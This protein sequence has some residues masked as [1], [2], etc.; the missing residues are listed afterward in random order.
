MRKDLLRVTM[1][2]FFGLA[3]SGLA[4]AVYAQESAS[5]GTVMTV[6]TGEGAETDAA[7]LQKEQASPEKI[8]ES[9]YTQASGDYAKGMAAFNRKHRSRALDLLTASARSGYVPAQ[10]QLGDM[11]D[12]GEMVLEN[13]Q[14]AFAWYSKAAELGSPEGEYR[15]GMMLL[16]GRG[17]RRDVNAAAEWLR[18]SAQKGYARAQ[19]NY[20]SLYLAG[21]GVEQDLSEAV[22]WFRKAAE[23]DYGDA[24]FLLGVA[25]EH[26][27]GVV[28]DRNAALAWYKRAAEN[29]NGKA[30]V[31]IFRLEGYQ[32]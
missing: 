19:T 5:A 24:Q 7:D 28:Q 14:T 16:R 6:E 21:W 12:T 20:G 2:I 15:T 23:Q 22:N 9:V 32:R 25:Y 27:E 18:R 17:V 3:W 29:E 8:T 10:L 1:V 26:G 13:T 11:Y 30:K 4:E 31:A